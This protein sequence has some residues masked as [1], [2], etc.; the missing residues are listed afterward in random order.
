MWAKRGRGNHTCP[1]VSPADF[2]ASNFR[3]R[4]KS[5][6]QA[7]RLLLRSTFL[8][9]MSL[10]FKKKKTHLESKRSGG[11]E[12]T[13]NESKTPP[14]FRNLRLVHSVPVSDG[15]LVTVLVSRDVL[16]QVGQAAGRRLSDVTQLVPGHHVGLQVVCQR[17]LMKKERGKSVL[18]LVKKKKNPLHG[19]GEQ[20]FYQFYLCT[21]QPRSRHT[22]TEEVAQP[23]KGHK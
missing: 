19:E 11:H 1:C 20:L 9:L 7:V 15:G 22:L 10:R 12:S 4:P 3:A 8:L 13:E 14:P 21:V 5:A 23:T 18:I 2:P 6:M 17:A 16:V